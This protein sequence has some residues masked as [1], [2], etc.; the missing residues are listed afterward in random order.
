M[1]QDLCLLPLRFQGSPKRLRLP[2][3]L[4]RQ[5]AD[6][7][8]TE[9][10]FL[11]LPFGQPR[12]VLPLHRLRIRLQ[13]FGMLQAALDRLAAALDHRRHRP[14][15]KVR[16]DPGQDQEIDDFEDERGDVETHRQTP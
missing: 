12:L 13:L 3:L 4:R 1:F 15:E 14:V 2:R 9:L 8:F 11:Y 5:I 10:T 7:D 6:P 16:Q